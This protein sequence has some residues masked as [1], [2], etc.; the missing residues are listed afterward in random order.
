MAALARLPFGIIPSLPRMG[1]AER[2]LLI[3]SL[4]I[5][6]PMVHRRLLPY[7]S[8]FVIAAGL[9]G[10]YALAQWQTTGSFTQSVEDIS[11]RMTFDKP[12]VVNPLVFNAMDAKLPDDELVI[13]VTVNGESRAYLRGAFERLSTR[14]VVNDVIGS[15]ALTVAHCD[16]TGCTRVFAK[17]AAKGPLD[18]R[19]GGFTVDDGLFLIYDGQRYPQTAADIPLD[20]IPYVETTWR[21][22]RLDHPHTLV[23]LGVPTNH[24]ADNDRS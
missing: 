6:T 8:A 18:V 24:S 21:Q 23:Y 9:N 7:L 4:E 19:I 17:E 16:R 11:S 1:A 5:S 15:I 12:G 22:W 13:G 10:V 2:C 20:E 3:V 14:H